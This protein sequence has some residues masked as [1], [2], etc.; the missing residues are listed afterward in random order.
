M[1]LG[2][3][4]QRRGILFNTK[5]LLLLNIREEGGKNHYKE[6]CVSALKLPSGLGRKQRCW[7]WAD[8]NGAFAGSWSGLGEK[9]WRQMWKTWKALGVGVET[10]RSNKKTEHS[11]RVSIWIMIEL[12]SQLNRDCIMFI[13]FSNLVLGW[14]AAKV[15]TRLSRD[16][17]IH[18]TLI[19]L[20]V[21][22]LRGRG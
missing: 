9:A 18:L 14:S 8:I 10:T 13:Y 5:C 21:S 16:G 4:N 22:P 7:F 6:V 12:C 19:G 1:L 15:T 2:R 11:W 17:I 20:K 3:V